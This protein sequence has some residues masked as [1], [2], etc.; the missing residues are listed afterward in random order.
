VITALL[1][2]A[3]YTLTAYVW[4]VLIVSALVA[5]RARRAADAAGLPLL[6]V[7][8][9]TPRSSLR[10]LCFGPTLW[11]DVNVDL[12]APRSV[13]HGS[14]RVSYGDA[15]ALPFATGAFGA[16]ICAHVLEHVR[17]PDA[18]ICEA[19][20]VARHVFFVVP[21]WWAPHTWL[22]PGHRWFFTR[23]L[24]RRWRLRH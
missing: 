3:A 18:A 14:D 19:H 7:G 12:A 17:D 2:F 9:G 20:R 16:V 21:S 22:H 5:R 4:D 10:A 13:A 23:D 8:A 6:N 11:G 1:V 24:K 15:E